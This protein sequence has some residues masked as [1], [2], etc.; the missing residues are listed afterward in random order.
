MLNKKLLEL[1]KCLDPTLH[2]KLRL[3]LLSPYFNKGSRAELLVRLYDHITGYECDENRPELAKDEVFHRFFPGL[4]FKTNEKSPLDSLTSELFLLVR[5]FLHLNEVESSDRDEK[6]LFTLA[7]FYRNNGLEDRFKQTIAALRKI[8]AGK[9][10]KDHDFFNAQYKLEIEQTQFQRLNI[11]QEDDANLIRVNRSLDLQ[12]LI[13]KLDLIFALEQQGR[14]SQIEPIDSKLTRTIRQEIHA[15]EYPETPLVRIYLLMLRLNTDTYNE[16]YLNELEILLNKHRHEIS[17][18]YLSLFHLY[19]RFFLGKFYLKT[20]EEK[21]RNK[22]FEVFKSDYENGFLYL[23]GQIAAN[24]LRTL[25]SLS[26]KVGEFNWIKVVL[27]AHPPEKIGGTKYAAELYSMNYAEYY[28]YLKNYD[29]ALERLVYRNFENPNYSILSDVL[30]IKIYYETQ[31]E[32]ASYR[33]HSMRQKVSR[34]N[35]SVEIKERYHNFLNKMD[36]IVKYGWEK[37]SPKLKKLR[38]EITSIPNIIEREWM[39]EKLE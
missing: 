24:S 22:M 25:L 28:F 29:E 18:D 13:Q 5:Q 20:G 10:I 9:K 30:L 21:I 14:L 12:Y 23:N 27:D 39:L 37:G 6:E 15:E 1:L 33:I 31:N 11:T 8:Q 32:L 3:F 34:S 26:L 2:K 36:K 19:Y 17:H 4:P 38:E 35:L 7:G 16:S